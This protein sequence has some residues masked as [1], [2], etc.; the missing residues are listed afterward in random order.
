[1][2]VAVWAQTGPSIDDLLR[3]SNEQS[4]QNELKTREYVYRERKVTD[5]VNEK[6]ESSNRH[7]E[8]WEAIGLE[9]SEYR[10]LI[11]RDDMPLSTREQKTEDERLRKESEKRRK[12][13]KLGIKNPLQRT[14]SF[15][16]SRGDER[17][18]DFRYMGEELTRGRA[19][20]V[21]EGIPKAH[22]MPTNNHEKQLLLSRVKLWI[23][24]EDTFVASIE[25]EVLQEGADLHPGTRLAL[26]QQRM[27]DG[28]WLLQE[29]R[30]RLVIKP[31]H[32]T[33]I[34]KD[35]VMTRS[36]YHKFSVDSRIIDAQ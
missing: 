21:F 25:I 33:N 24:K 5:D 35:L 27:E 1:M 36:D 26:T 3:R 31:L 29:L 13:K 10:K 18:F 16:Y 9:G 4:K 20:Y 12:A 2:S 14:Y 11:Q 23:D 6:G 19:S 22:Q 32:V 28:T 15:G 8:T 34:R 7:T 17:F 30:G